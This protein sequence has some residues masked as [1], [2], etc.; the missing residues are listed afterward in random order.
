MLM[1]S[2][3]TSSARITEREVQEHKPGHAAMFNNVLGRT[4]HD[5]WDAVRFE[6]SCNQTHGLVTDR[7][8]RCHH[9]QVDVVFQAAA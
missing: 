8:N 4:E 2:I 3:E 5:R 1:F 9:R 7:S 6:V